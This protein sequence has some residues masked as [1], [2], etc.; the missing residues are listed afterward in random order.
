MITQLNGYWDNLPDG[1]GSYPKGMLKGF[2]ANELKEDIDT[3]FI[4]LDTGTGKPHRAWKGSVSH[5]VFSQSKVT[6]RV[7][8]KKE[9]TVPVKYRDYRIGWYATKR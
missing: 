6:F 9:I 3:T 7:N 5:L 2:Q 4:K 8:L 1:I